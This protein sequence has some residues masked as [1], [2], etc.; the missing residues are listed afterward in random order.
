MWIWFIKKKRK[1]NLLVEKS[2]Y[3]LYF[4]VSS[5][6][7]AHS[8]K[9][10]GYAHVSTHYSVELRLEYSS[11]RLIPKVPVAINYRVIQNRLMPAWFLIQVCNESK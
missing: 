9:N 6:T 3:F 7:T 1:R 5:Y 8:S 4:R 11:T 2:F 10:P